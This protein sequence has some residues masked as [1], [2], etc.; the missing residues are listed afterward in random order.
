[1]LVVNRV[2]KI[3][4]SVSVKTTRSSHSGTAW[5]FP[6]NWPG[7]VVVDRAMMMAKNEG[8]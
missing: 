8:E 4:F 7:C 2:K 6:Y 5:N 3:E 1:M